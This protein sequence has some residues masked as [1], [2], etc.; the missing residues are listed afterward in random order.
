MTR[1]FS[2]RITWVAVADGEKALL[3]RNADVDAHPLLRLVSAEEID[4][5]PTREQVTDAAGRNNDGR[6]GGV[7]RSAFEETDFHR[8]AKEE[9]AHAFAD[10]LNR[11][12][13]RNAFDR[14][15]VIAPAMTLGA[16]RAHFGAD[17][18]KRLVWE[19]DKD[20]TKHPLADIER[21]V[22]DVFARSSS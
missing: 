5:P 8:L 3:L 4:N 22:A 18:K 1:D 19:V 2:D 21:H 16:L 20:L 13:R 11:A 9:F 12:A 17:L 10:R 6:A 7:R 14:L 15:I